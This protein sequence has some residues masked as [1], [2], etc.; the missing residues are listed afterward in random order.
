[1]E[2]YDLNDL[3]QRLQEW[4]IEHGPSGAFAGDE[5]ALFDNISQTALGSDTIRV[6]LAV[7]GIC[8]QGSCCVEIGEQQ[9]LFSQNKYIVILPGQLV[10]VVSTSP[11]FRPIFISCDRRL[12]AEVVQLQRIIVPMLL[13]I[14]SNP[15]ETLA[16]KDVVWLTDYYRLLF[17]EVCNT[18]NIFRK[19]TAKALLF[20]MLAKIC[21]LY[22][23]EGTLRSTPVSGRQ[24]EV[25][26]NFVKELSIG[27]K[28]H[29]DLQYYADKLCIT[30]KYLSAIVKQVSGTSAL[31]LIESCIVE[32]TKVLLQTTS[33]TIQQISD[34]LN[35]P[36]Q[37]FFGKYI[38]K[39][40]GLSPK[41]LRKKLQSI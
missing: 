28:H 19:N 11:D 39:R 12:F 5:I 13:Y 34:E 1:M 7:F 15:C 24:E 37:S 2:L 10:R 23:H 9:Y 36:N 25:F 41:D 17:A 8:L 22:A 26:S 16:E 20:A 30:P 18:D 40:T 35:F 32:E 29:R 21:N 14:R 38:K 3:Q 27:F 4:N 33:M 6:E 31:Q